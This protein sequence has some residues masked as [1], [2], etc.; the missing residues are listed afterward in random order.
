MMA[1][2]PEETGPRAWRVALRL[3]DGGAAAVIT[4]KKVIARTALEALDVVAKLVMHGRDGVDVTHVNIREQ[5]LREHG[6]FG[7]ADATAPPPGPPVVV[8]RQSRQP[9]D[10]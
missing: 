10:G 3:E 5:E 7:P 1:L 2:L 8:V 9:G 6:G 4:Y